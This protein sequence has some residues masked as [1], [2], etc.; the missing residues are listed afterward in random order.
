MARKLRFFDPPFSLTFYERLRKPHLI[1]TPTVTVPITVE[2]WQH[3][4]CSI[5][6]EILSETQVTPCFHRFCKEC[7]CK[8]IEKNPEPKDEAEPEAEPED[9]YQLAKNCPK[10][11][12]NI[13]AKR[14]LKA[15][16]TTD[17][18]IALLLLNGVNAPPDLELQFEE[19]PRAVVSCFLLYY[20]GLIL[21]NNLVAIFEILF[22]NRKG[23][24]LVAQN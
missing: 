18:F 24:W 15:D 9:E 2:L 5:C 3:F 4:R 11:R 20:T 22:V 19:M 13:P 7:I 16:P 21:T 14:H 6:L 17:A 12:K 8:W 23:K 1:S 10:C